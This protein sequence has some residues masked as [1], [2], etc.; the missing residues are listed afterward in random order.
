MMVINKKKPGLAGHIL[1]KRGKQ[2]G[3]FF[4]DD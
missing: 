1:K 4:E 2:Y 3:R